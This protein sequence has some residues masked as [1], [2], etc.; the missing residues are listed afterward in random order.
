MHWCK[1]TV[2]S[3]ILQLDLT[4]KVLKGDVM[5]KV[6][7]YIHNSIFPFFIPLLFSWVKALSPQVCSLVLVYFVWLHPKTM[8]PYRCII[9]SFIII[10]LYVENPK[11]AWGAA[12][13]ARVYKLGNSKQIDI[14]SSISFTSCLQH[15]LHPLSQ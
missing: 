4:Q 12:V 8:H 13:G 7:S 6:K 5:F 11:P 9:R 1:T 14:I 15:G 10:L 3:A 2:C